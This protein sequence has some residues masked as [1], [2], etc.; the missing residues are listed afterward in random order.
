MRLAS[1]SGGVSGERLAGGEGRFIEANCTVVQGF[2]RQNGRDRLAGRRQDAMLT[3]GT[4][5]SDAA[6]MAAKMREMGA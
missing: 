1:E 2:R 3:S 5:L 6:E 4:F